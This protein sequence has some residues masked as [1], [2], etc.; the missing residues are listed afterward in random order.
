MQYFCKLFINTWI[1]LFT[2]LCAVPFGFIM[3]PIAVIYKSAEGRKFSFKK[4][5]KEWIVFPLNELYKL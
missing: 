5:I 3:L 1:I 4:H 2:I